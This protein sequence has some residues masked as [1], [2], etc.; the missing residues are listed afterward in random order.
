LSTSADKG[1]WRLLFHDSEEKNR[2]RIQVHDTKSVARVDADENIK[3]LLEAIY[4]RGGR[5]AMRR[6]NAKVVEGF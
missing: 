2:G 3:S 6:V 5:R 1:D 4:G